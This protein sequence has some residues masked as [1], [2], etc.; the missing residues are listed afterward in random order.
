MLE[1]AQQLLEEASAS[2]AEAKQLLAW[3]GSSH[4]EANVSAE[5]PVAE[6]TVHITLLLQAKADVDAAKAKIAQAASLVAEVEASLEAS[7]ST[8]QPPKPG[9]GMP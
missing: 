8:P 5:T 7:G 3:S 2:L 4:A 9:H 1:Q 6:I